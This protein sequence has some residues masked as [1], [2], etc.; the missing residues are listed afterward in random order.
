MSSATTKDHEE[1]FDRL[2]EAVA[3]WEHSPYYL[4]DKELFDLERF[5]LDNHAH[6]LKRE[7]EKT[8]G[9]P[10][11]EKFWTPSLNYQRLKR[12]REQVKDMDADQERRRQEYGRAVEESRKNWHQWLKGLSVIHRRKSFRIISGREK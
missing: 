1:L 4:E 10:L 8:Y 7:L 11:N 5:L 2:S 9:M 3:E 6:G 12:A